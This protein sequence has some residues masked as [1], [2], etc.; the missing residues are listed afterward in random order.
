MES[1]EFKLFQRLTSYS[2]S[3]DEDCR[4]VVTLKECPFF[5]TF[6]LPV[7]LSLFKKMPSTPTKAKLSKDCFLILLGQ[8]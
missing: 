7:I 4:L 5:A 1:G 3:I 8:L 6:A 2:L